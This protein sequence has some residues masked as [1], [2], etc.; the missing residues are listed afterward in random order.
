[1]TDVFVF[2]RAALPWLAIGF[3]VAYAFAASKDEKN[4]KKMSWGSYAPSVA[5]V[6]V[7][8]M[9]LY[10]RDFSSGATWL[11]L[12]AAFLAFNVRQINKK[13]SEELEN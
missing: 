8:L 4:G 13:K 11:I 9:E 3:W 6:F 12:A 1:M 10:D 5:M 7:A 2:V